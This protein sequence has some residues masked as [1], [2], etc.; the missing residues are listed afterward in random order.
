MNLSVWVQ[1]QLLCDCECDKEIQIL[2]NAGNFLS[3]LQPVCFSRRNKFIV[4]VHLKESPI[5]VDT[6]V[7]Q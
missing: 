1:G 4:Y 7:G 6:P 5:A 3:S 2:Y